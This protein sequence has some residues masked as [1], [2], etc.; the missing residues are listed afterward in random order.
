MRDWPTIIAALIVLAAAWQTGREVTM[1][2]PPLRPADVLSVASAQRNASDGVVSASLRLS[3]G[4]AVL[5]GSLDQTA[6]QHELQLIWHADDSSSTHLLTTSH[7]AMNFPSDWQLPVDVVLPKKGHS[8]DDKTAS[9]ESASACFSHSGSVN[10]PCRLR[11]GRP[12]RFVVPFFCGQTVHDRHVLATEIARG[13]RV[14]VYLVNGDESAFGQNPEDAGDRAWNVAS[15]VVQRTESGVLG[16]VESQLGAISDLDDDGRL[17]F[18]MG[19]LSEHRSAECDQQPITGC[20]RPEDFLADLRTAESANPG[21]DIVYLDCTLPKGNEL[22][23]VLAHELAHAATFCLINETGDP[24]R[25]QLPAWLNEAVAHYIELQVNPRSG[26]LQRRLT[27]FTQKPNGFPVVIPDSLRQL[28]LRRGPARAA[29]C[30]FLS[31]ALEKLP[32]GSLKNLVCSSQAGTQRLE[33]VT[34]ESFPE[35]FRRWGLNLMKSSRQF[36]SHNIADGKERHLYLAGT[37]FAWTVPVTESG[38]LEI[39]APTDSQLQVTIVRSGK[40]RTTELSLNPR[41]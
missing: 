3:A 8:A 25:C 5:F 37:A 1:T 41:L 30:L 27:E 24:K 9:D 22:D 36:P 40:M 11:N 39:T 35:I 29:A 7:H 19:Q 4:S 38:T 15:D 10:S 21:G 17:S 6:T 13:D 23:A 33:S 2:S 16:F 32:A 28:S 12:R 31:S 20:V 26:N 14:S 18:V 34:G